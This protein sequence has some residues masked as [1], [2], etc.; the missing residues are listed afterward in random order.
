MKYLIDRKQ[1]LYIYIE[2]GEAFI[3][4]EQ[5]HLWDGYI[6]LVFVLFGFVGNYPG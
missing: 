5:Y 3:F 4:L 2:D 1:N 6:V